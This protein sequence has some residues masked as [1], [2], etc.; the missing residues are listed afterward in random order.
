MEEAGDGPGRTQELHGA[1]RSNWQAWRNENRGFP[2]PK[3]EPR[4]FMKRKNPDATGSC[5][6][7]GNGENGCTRVQ[8]SP[9]GGSGPQNDQAPETAIGW[10]KT[11]GTKMINPIEV[12]P[13]DSPTGGG[14][15]SVVDPCEARNLEGWK[16]GEGGRRKAKRPKRK[17]ENARPT[18]TERGDFE[19]SKKKGE[20][21]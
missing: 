15:R 2:Q 4:G 12:F 9:D 1:M 20:R 17:G 11:P 16:R 10:G 14:M 13:G 3:A 7:C 18:E 6:Q 21:R 19:P 5:Q 8:G